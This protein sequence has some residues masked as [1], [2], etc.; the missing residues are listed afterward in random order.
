V[1]DT[2]RLRQLAIDAIAIQD[3]RG[4]P[5]VAVDVGDLGDS[6]AM[7]DYLDAVGPR[8]ILELLDA[9]DQRDWQP[10]DSE[11]WRS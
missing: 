1:I 2:G 9:L 3:R 6:Q 8:T 5:E 10:P 11:D 7:M 4:D